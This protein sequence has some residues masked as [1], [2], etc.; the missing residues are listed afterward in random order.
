[1]ED[2]LKNSPQNAIFRGNEDLLQQN[3]GQ[4]TYAESI[5]SNNEI[6]EEKKK[7]M[8]LRIGTLLKMDNVSFL[9]GAGASICSG[10]ISLSKIPICIEKELLKDGCN[11]GKRISGWLKLFYMIVN[12][13]LESSYKPKERY[14]ILIENN[15]SVG[16]SE[17]PL[18]YEKLLT[19]IWMLD[20][21][22]DLKDVSIF[23]EDYEGKKYIIKKKVLTTLKIKLTEKLVARC[24]L[25]DSSKASGIDT[26]KKFIQKLLTRPL[27]LKRV[28]IFTLNYDTLIEQASDACGIFLIDGFLGN[29]D[30]VFRPESYDYDLYY[31]AQTTEGRVHRYDKVLNLY[32]LHG[33]INW[34]KNK[35]SIENPYGISRKSMKNHNQDEELII[36][37]T[38]LKYAQ[39]LGLPYSE[40]FRRF[41]AAISQPQS[42]LFIIGYGFGDDHIN[43]IIHQALAIPSFTLI[44]ID[45]NPDNDFINNLK[46]SEDERIII[47][48]GNTLGKFENF[49]NTLLPNLAQEE[50]EKKVINTYNELQK[51]IEN[52][53]EEI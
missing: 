31:P 35:A 9:L 51:A 23:I 10:G 45:P 30:P 39:T 17:I 40:L 28:N 47:I 15:N 32:K 7:E 37:P 18:N 50:I 22:T 11:K 14:D 29:L 42:A 43:A 12:K 1:M 48:Q 3:S 2:N 5:D 4:K 46:K 41:A 49:T 24:D 26:H 6:S 52:Q 36:Y 8:R 44:I 33:S 34:Y 19:N 53:K 27:N 20:S 25:P 38:T 16:A 13:L 21:T